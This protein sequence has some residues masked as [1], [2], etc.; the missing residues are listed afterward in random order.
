M[1]YTVRQVTAV[2]LQ[3]EDHIGMLSQ[4]LRVLKNEG[5]NMT[6]IVSQRKAGAAIMGIPED[7]E[8][9]RKLASR[10]GVAFT[11]REVFYV[12]GEDEVGALCDI[13]DKLAG[14]RINIEDV[15][16]LSSKGYYA[17][18]YTVA[19]GDVERAAEALG[20]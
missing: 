8:A 14:A 6:A 2:T 10:E 9:A 12:E 20:L 16:A 7:L 18:I 17:A 1:A 15:Y 3:V 19:A 4:A 13:T 11:T 5:V